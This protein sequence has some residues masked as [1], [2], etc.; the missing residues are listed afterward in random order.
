[1]GHPVEYLSDRLDEHGQGGDAEQEVE[2]EL[3]HGGDVHGLLVEED[4]AGSN[5]I[6]IGLPGKLILR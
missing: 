3:D 4:A 6:K 5:C 1:M 2:E